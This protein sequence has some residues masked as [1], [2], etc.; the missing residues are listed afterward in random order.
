MRALALLPLLLVLPGCGLDPVTGPTGEEG[1][2]SF[3]DLTLSQESVD[4]GNVA[5]NDSAVVTLTLGNTGDVPLN[6]L[7]AQIDTSFFLVEDAANMLPSEIAA[8][9]ELSM[10]LVFTPDREMDFEGT[11]TIVT[12]SAAASEITVDLI[13]SGSEVVDT[14]DTGVAV[15]Q[16]SVS[17]S[18]IDFGDV[19]MNNE[20]RESFNVTNNGDEDVLII[21]VQTE[22]DVF[23]YG[24]DLALPYVLGAGETRSMSAVAY[25]TSIGSFSGQL[26]IGSD[27][28]NSELTV[29]LS[30]SS[31]GSPSFDLL[32]PS[33]QS[34]GTGNL[35][36]QSITKTKSI[37]I[38]N[39]NG[40]SALSVTDV[41]FSNPTDDCGTLTMSGWGGTKTVGPGDTYDLTFTYTPG[42]S[43]VVFCAITEDVVISTNAGSASKTI[44]GQR[45]GL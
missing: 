6:I 45:F 7:D 36:L 1:P 3:G 33:C 34:G 38:S 11:L 30:A 10:N 17:T 32:C 8:G 19:P 12:D 4:F 21:N 43:E 2:V 25:P 31:S 39:G 18:S 5:P 20:T 23:E 22:G 44:K 37:T 41:A 29:D 16:L 15:G 26:T 24:G 13:G 42:T 9:G 27:A 40:T 14:G 35:L 28:A